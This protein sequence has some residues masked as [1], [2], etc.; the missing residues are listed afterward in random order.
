MNQDTKK[1]IQAANLL[2]SNDN[3]LP[4]NNDYLS[5]SGKNNGFSNYKEFSP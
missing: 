2:N 1:R 4:K 3:Q 5:Q